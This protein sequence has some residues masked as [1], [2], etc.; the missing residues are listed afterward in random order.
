MEHYAKPVAALREAIQA[1]NSPVKLFLLQN[2]YPAGDE[3]A[4]VL[5]VTGRTVP[6]RASPWTREPWYPTLRR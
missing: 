5:E 1:L 6:R 2:F 4:L 3:Q